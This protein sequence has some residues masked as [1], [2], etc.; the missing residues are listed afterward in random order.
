[1]KII[2]GLGNPGKQHE[3][4][5]HN[6]GFLVLDKIAENLQAQRDFKENKRLKSEILKTTLGNEVVILA[7]PK[8]F[9][10]LSGQA[11]QAILSFHKASIKNLLVIHDDLDLPLGKIRF[12]RESGPA[13][14]NGVSSII[15]SLGTNDFIRLRVG[16]ATESNLAT[17]NKNFVLGKFSSE[18]ETKIKAAIETATDATEFY[19]KEGFE[20]SA[21]K[22]N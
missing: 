12:S 16:I 7:K 8:T 21:A 2:I 19:V 6:L 9:M 3:N 4:T 20:K 14:H 1:M 18:E 22:Y 13:G 5:R 10:N 11:V 17:R 15:E